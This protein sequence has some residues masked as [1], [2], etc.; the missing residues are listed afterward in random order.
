MH[1]SRIHNVRCIGNPVRGVPALGG[2]LPRGDVCSGEGDFH[3]PV[4]RI[5]D[6]RLL[7][8]YLSATTV[9]DGKYKQNNCQFNFSVITHTVITHFCV[10]F[11]CT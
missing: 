5:L 11:S 9:A 3:P 10:L 4:N 6:T 8:D 7:K 2:C 1:S